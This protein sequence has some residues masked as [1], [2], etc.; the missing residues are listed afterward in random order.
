MTR[1]QPPREGLGVGRG[2]LRE[3]GE[4]EQKEL[5][6]WASV[7]L[8]ILTKRPTNSTFFKR[9]VSNSLV[10]TR[11]TFFHDSTERAVSSFSH[12]QLALAHLTNAFNCLF[13]KPNLATEKDNLTWEYNLLSDRDKDEPIASEISVLVSKRGQQKKLDGCLDLVGGHY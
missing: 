13:L 11:P 4:G 2:D 10:K 8:I 3:D 1:E 7:A 12:G 5:G 6:N 9:S